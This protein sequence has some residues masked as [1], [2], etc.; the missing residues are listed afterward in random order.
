[1]NKWSVLAVLIGTSLVVFGL[2]VFFSFKPQ[3]LEM[4]PL[5]KGDSY[6]S[7]WKKVQEFDSDGLTQSAQ[8]EVQAIYEVAK[9]EENPAQIV[10]SLLYLSRYTRNLEQESFL[11]NINRLREEEAN[12]TFPLKPVLQSILAE[13]YFQYASS[14]YWQFQNRT[15]TL[16]F[17][18]ED[19]TTWDLKTLYRKSQELYLASLTNKDSL[20]R[21]QVSIYDDILE[22]GNRPSRFRPTLYDFL[23]H[24][25]LDAFVSEAG[26]LPQ[27]VYRFEIEGTQ[28][29]ASASR[30]SRLGLSTSD[31]LSYKYHALC[32]FQDLLD[33][34]LRDEDPTALV[35]ADLKRLQ[36]VYANSLHP[37]KEKLY[38]QALEKL[39]K[40]HRKYEISSWVSYQLAMYW[41]QQG[42][43]YRPFSEQ[44]HHR[45]DRKTAFEIATRGEKRFPV[46]LG[47]LNCQSV[48]ESILRGTLDLQVERVNVP[49]QPFR[50][51]LTFQNL[52]Q[53]WFRIV[54]LE[55][56]YWVGQNDRHGDNFLALAMEL[57]PVKTWTMELPDPEDYQSHSMEIELPEL[58]IGSYAIL[59][60]TN[61]AFS[62]KEEAVMYTYTHV[63]NLA[64]TRR[65]DNNGLS[66]FYVHDRVSGHALPGARAQIW[67]RIY[68]YQ[69]Y[70]YQFRKKEKI[71]ADENGSFRLRV[72]LDRSRDFSVELL[73]Q[74]DRLFT[75]E[76]INEYN[77]G[78]NHGENR[79][80]TTFFTDRSIYRPGQ[81]I[82]FKGILLNFQGE[83]PRIRPNTSTTVEL[84]DVNYQRIDKV[85]LRSNE[86]GTVEGTFTAP[87]GG[88][89]GQM[90]IRN[91]S[92]IANISVEEYKRP[93]FE[94]EFEPVKESFRLGEKVI[95]TGNGKA[96][97]GS[98][99]DG[100]QVKYRITRM[101]SYPY[102]YGWYFWGMPGIQPVEIGHGTTTTDENGDF[103]V[104]FTAHPDKSAS[105][106]R[107]PQFAYTIHADVTDISGETRSAQTVVNVG[108]VALN[109]NIDLPE[110]VDQEQAGKF[111]L[112]TTNLNY[113]PI[114]AQGDIEVFQL[115][116]PESF[117]RNR[118]W[119]RADLTEMDAG[120]YHERFPHDVFTD[121]D[122]FKTW[123]K[124][125]KVFSGSFNTE[126]QDSLTLSGLS[127]WDEG[128]YVL[129]LETKD[130]FGK[131]VTLKKYF[132]VYAQTGTA[133]PTPELLMVEEVNTTVEPGDTAV[134]LVGSSAQD[135]RVLFEV[136]FKGKIVSSEWITLNNEK[137]RLEI[138][139][140]EKHR[141]NLGYYLTLVQEG[142]FRHE[143]RSVY[144]PWSNKQLLLEFE[145]FRDKLQPGQ[146]EEWRLKI[147]GP[148][149]DAVAA[150]MVAAMY[151][152][153]LDAF[154]SN[155]WGFSPW[156]T[157]GN[158][159]SWSG[160]IGFNTGEGVMVQNDW[161]T[162]S[163]Y[164]YRSY[165]RIQWFGWNGY[166]TRAYDYGGSFTGLWSANQQRE[167]R[168]DM[169]MLKGEAVPPPGPALVP[170][171]KKEF[172]ADGD[173]L[174]NSM[175]TGNY[176]VTVMDANGAS[177][178][179]VDDTMVAMGERGEGRSLGKVKVRTNLNETAFFFPKLKTNEQGEVILSFTVPE[180]LTRW[181][182]MGMAHTVDLKT[183]QISKETVTQ[184]SLMIMP[185]NPRFFRENDQMVF[186]A[187]VSN[188][189]EK[190]LKGTA[191]LELI[192]ALTGN[193][194]DAN[195]QNMTQ[196]QDFE[197][198]QGQS[199]PLAWK[200]AIP[201][202][203]P[204]VTVRV[205]ARA[206]RFTDGEES[207]I[208]V[209][210]NRMLVTESMPLPVREGQTKEF[211]FEKMANQTSSTLKHHR[212]TLEFTS[213]P[214]WYAIQALPY[215][216]EYP[217]ECNE[218]I[219]SRFYAN[220]IASHVANSSPKTKAVFDQWKNQDSKAL[221]SNLE[222]NEELKAVLLEETPW[223]LQAQDETTR[224]KRVGLLFDLNRMS[225]E[226]DRAIVKLEQNQVSNG[227]W[228]WF[229]GGP[230]SRYITQHIVTGMGHLDHL[231]VTSVKRDPRTWNMTRK[232]VLYCDRQIHED[233][234]RLL[235]SPADTSL[236]RL[237]GIQ[238]QYLY[239]RTYFPDIPVSAQNQT[240]YKYYLSRIDDI[241]L[242]ESR[243]YQGMMALILHRTDQQT[244]AMKIIRS[245]KE[246]S[247][248]SEELGRYWKSNSG[249]F[250]WYQA[251]I[252][253]QAL[254]IE[255]FD[256]VADDQDAVAEMKVWLLKQKQTQDWKT[257]K[258][259]VEACY[260]L[261]LR[262]TDLLA[263]SKLADITVGGQKLDPR[264]MENVQVE[265]GTGYFKTAW[266]GSEITPE[267][268]T[269]KVKNN[270]Q[271]A[272]WGAV[273]WQYFEQLDKITPAETPLKLE[274]Q[275]FR[276][277]NGDRGPV[278]TPI[279]E[280]TH[281]KPGDKVKV[282]IELRVDRRMEYL[283]LK[284]MRA[285]GFEPMNVFSRYKYQGG[286]G[287][288]ESTRDAATNFFITAINPGTYV[289][290]YPL[291]V[292]HAG[293]FSN[294]ITTIQCMY[295]P[296]FSSHSEGIR[297]QVQ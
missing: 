221:V 86:Y 188:L 170:L 162:P 182:M 62:S 69:Y 121:E 31:T 254:L 60:S 200:L 213:N 4:L 101:V 257:T 190:D 61:E 250:Y 17:E 96:Y 201:E 253:T 270:N 278:I 294:G 85:T 107:L 32:I 268:A 203:V 193:P 191:Q 82:Y 29:F 54:E 251:P 14:N 127:K 151:D 150:E 205:K 222:K 89:T 219:F 189:S 158:A 27:P 212:Y 51:K 252:E 225:G 275:L 207:Q 75:N 3:P 243:Y 84:F 20:M 146:E 30:F 26:Y 277:T 153:S 233:F 142:R 297:V 50:G 279:N 70:A 52:P 292:T 235:D 287:Y 165:A 220:S 242:N 199:A 117:F 131:K 79:N 262:G 282:R 112:N 224:K 284:D 125:E 18:N 136:E 64:L 177:V 67:E 256:E 204:A 183:G 120:E 195:F 285:A 63:S 217:Y 157:R 140:E 113:E 210:T 92:G 172:E 119:S 245:L 163:P 41:F 16:D 116:Q 33:L 176:A 173:F 141:G 244:T 10:K 181:K 211:T 232:A 39:E 230:D 226:L 175:A 196:M 161:R 234:K 290:E 6:N 100:A 109:V 152:A 12:A 37:D 87:S 95:V 35:D 9:K 260:A 74:D 132:T 97:A 24:R 129:E 93:K 247:I 106:E 248:N 273:Y 55:P 49:N 160:T 185:N 169:S 216:M 68:N 34:H 40:N 135:A 103:E 13:V 19:I 42:S 108:H 179:E 2:S 184:K 124:S 289:F 295:A 123:E 48:K 202:D 147:A 114:S 134:I 192:N 283:H 263:E 72:G 58:P 272:A 194:V 118:M 111:K 155:Y 53:V 25:A 171:E 231:G 266:S 98:Q 206:N 28:P 65:Y 44:E 23:A 138:P 90:T 130:K 143:S 218:Q 99:I 5:T 180:A 227:G 91:S 259:T 128:K 237:S 56:E 156:A 276:E 174:T 240:A 261:L 215:L 105:P 66:T 168:P 164:N 228:P 265:A 178:T 137:K 209:L 77:Y 214:A 271:V 241:W 88:V 47:G 229:Q 246:N 258:A 110:K 1:M 38:Y 145:T 239:A 166:H 264:T 288:Y 208:P 43:R 159:Y 187:K 71:T 154:Q 133:M 7:Q 115:A 238:I 122:D 73:H 281:L 255:A 286:L 148:K 83:T 280:N 126:E 144:V 8:K 81:S 274:K 94:V 223:V 249:G 267:M 22:S 57:D 198:K 45:Y 102:W 149:G 15:E 76:I 139:I 291:R 80:E 197:V 11:I 296:E 78:R 59:V 46:S 104:E 269:V 236:Y 167:V 186:T 36:F 293:D 21:T